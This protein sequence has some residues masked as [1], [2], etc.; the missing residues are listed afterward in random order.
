VLEELAV[1]GGPDIET[2]P[3]GMSFGGIMFGGAPSI[4]RGVWAEA[5]E[6]KGISAATSPQDRAR[7]FRKA[8]KDL[9][10]SGAI[11]QLAERIIL[12]RRPEEGG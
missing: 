5:C 4:P 7:V 1:G 11:L 8:V 10:A 9:L 2:V 12:L 6:L 3:D